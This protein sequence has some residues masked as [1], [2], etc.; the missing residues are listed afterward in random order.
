MSGCHTF[1]TVKKAFSVIL[2]ISFLLQ[3]FAYLV[4]FADYQIN[5][6]YIAKVECENRNRPELKCEGKCQLCKKMKAEENKDTKGIPS[7]KSVK[8]IVLFS[9]KNSL[10]KI[11]NSDLPI[12]KTY[13]YIAGI[14]SLHKLAI[15]HPPLV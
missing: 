11:G 5:K 8:Q 6:R 9:I 15:F 13:C 1:V 10:F 3:S 7:T 4:I 14:S 2:S 12:Q